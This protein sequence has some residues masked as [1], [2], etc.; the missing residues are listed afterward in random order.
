MRTI[1]STLFIVEKVQ[2]KH[3][4]TSVF[5]LLTVQLHLTIPLILFEV[6]S[7]DRSFLPFGTF[8]FAVR[9]P[10]TGRIC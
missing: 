10:K 9:K 7:Q 5:I 4:S 3:D 1:Q 2:L 8:V 6:F